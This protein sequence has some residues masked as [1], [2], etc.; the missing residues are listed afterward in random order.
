[1]VNQLVQSRRTEAGHYSQQLGPAQSQKT[2]IQGHENNKNYT[3]SD[4]EID[5]DLTSLD[6]PPNAVPK[7]QSRPVARGPAPFMGL[8][9]HNYG[10]IS[11]EE[12]DAKFPPREPSAIEPSKPS[13]QGKPI[14]LPPR[15]NNP[16]AIPRF[17]HL[18][19]VHSLTSSFTFEEVEQGLFSSKLAFGNYVYEEAG[20]FPS[21]KLAK[22]AVALR[23][24]STLETIDHSLL[25]NEKV[26]STKRKSVDNDA[27]DTPEEANGDWVAILH[28]FTQKHHHDQPQFQFFEV[29]T[30]AK[31]SRGLCN[32]S[33]QFCCTLKVQARPHHTFGS[34]TTPHIT[35]AEAKRSAA[36]EAVTW[37]QLVGMLPDTDTTTSSKRRKSTS[38]GEA[39]TGL[40]QEVS[41]LKTEQSPTQL[42]SE[43]SL[44]LGLSQPQYKCAPTVGNFYICTAHYIDRDVLRQPRLEGPLCQTEAVYGQK[45]AKKMCA[46]ELIAVLEA[47]TSV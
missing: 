38:D 31:Q 8:P 7:M 20:P 5:F 43:L 16:E 1:M 26:Q 47:L 30:R 12:W 4:M 14:A 35:K 32:S 23:G 9:K 24:L 21:K 28:K 41:R 17:N 6:H 11:I 36:K 46:Q 22:E 15:S 2:W 33:S 29:D 37:L 42:V 45:N 13:T 18:C 3:M 10:T 27:G 25:K 44:R 39:H 34:D 19:Q 40:T